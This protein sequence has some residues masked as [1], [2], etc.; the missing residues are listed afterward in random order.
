MEIEDFD[1]KIAAEDG[2][3]QFDNLFNGNE[4]L[5]KEMNNLLNEN[6][7]QVFNDAKPGYEVL[8]G[9]VFKSYF[10]LVLSKVPY[11]EAFP[12]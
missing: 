1:Y 10:N 7:K 2:S 6:W 12:L 9:T 5:G 3:F 8:F 11:L 4:K